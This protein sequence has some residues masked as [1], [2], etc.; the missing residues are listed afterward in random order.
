MKKFLCSTIMTLCCLSVTTTSHATY[1]KFTITNSSSPPN[2]AFCQLPI[3]IRVLDKGT[4][5]TTTYG[6]KPLVAGDSDTIITHDAGK[7]TSI[8]LSAVC[9]GTQTS[10]TTKC[11]NGFILIT[12]PGSMKKP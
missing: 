7:C 10:L 11:D 5:V 2:S 8:E 9:S 4:T 3:Q 12:A 1:Y 6:N